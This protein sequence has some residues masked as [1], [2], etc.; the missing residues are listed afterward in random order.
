MLR[1]GQSIAASS[2]PDYKVQEGCHT[3]RVQR[4]LVGGDTRN[5]AVL[6]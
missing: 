2:Q 5:A 3:G 1:A 4:E 6:R